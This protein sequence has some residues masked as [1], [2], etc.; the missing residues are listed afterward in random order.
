M[1]ASSLFL[2]MSREFL[3]VDARVSVHLFVDRCVEAT[4]TIS[5]WRGP[6]SVPFSRLLDGIEGLDPKA[7]SDY[8]R[9]FYQAAY[10]RHGVP[11]TGGRDTILVVLGDARNNL[12]DPQSWVFD[13]L[14]SRCRRVIWLNPEPVSRWNTGDSDLAEY[15]PHCDVLCEAMNLEGIARGI[16]E[17][18]GALRG[19]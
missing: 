4:D 7:A 16:A 15:S 3:A 18:V 9:A 10:A 11:R 2:L 6:A 14:A 5:R 12:R 13:E 17:L 19:R 8:G 1:R